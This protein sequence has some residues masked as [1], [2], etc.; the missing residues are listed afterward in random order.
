M[1]IVRWCKFFGHVPKL[2]FIVVNIF[3]S[4]SNRNLVILI[5]SCELASIKICYLH[6]FGLNLEFVIRLVVNIWLMKNADL[7]S[8]PQ[9]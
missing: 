7:K 2:T 1:D 4:Y 3:R 5:R 8:V 6:N 9:R